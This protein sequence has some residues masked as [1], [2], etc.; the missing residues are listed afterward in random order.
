MMAAVLTLALGFPSAVEAQVPAPPP[1]PAP[2]VSDSSFRAYLVRFEAGLTAGLNGDSALYLENVSHTDD[3]TLFTPFGGIRRGW[4]AVAKQYLFA[5]GRFVPC[6]ASV[7][8]EYLSVAVS[9]DLAYTVTL[10]RS[11]YCQ[12]GVEG[13]QSGLTRVTQ[14]YRRENGSWRMLHRHMDHLQEEPATKP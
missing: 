8:I 11:R 14:V 7:S 9:G 4:P 1:M 5:L 3:V 10:E 2:V 12:R 6:G 13:Q